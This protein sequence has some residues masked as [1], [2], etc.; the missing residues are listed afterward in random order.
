VAVAVAV[1]EGVALGALVVEAVGV[2]VGVAV[3]VWVAVAVGRL[4]WVAVEVGV[5]VGVRV[6]VAVAV[7]MKAT[8]VGM[9]VTVAGWVAVGVR[10]GAIV[11][12]TSGTARVQEASSIIISSSPARVTI[13][14]PSNQK[15]LRHR[16]RANRAAERGKKREHFAMHQNHF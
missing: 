13:S 7:G 6:A 3:A 2:R 15:P 1:K 8:T 16:S 9:G 10:V 14:T 5:G 4:V 11:G 12:V